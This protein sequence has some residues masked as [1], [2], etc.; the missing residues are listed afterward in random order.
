MQWELKYDATD[1]CSCIVITKYVN[2][3]IE[4]ALVLNVMFLSLD[5]LKVLNYKGK[6]SMLQKK[7]IFRVK[8]SCSNRCVVKG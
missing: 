2:I 7:I 6:L 4:V 3:T 5:S 8:A 1:L